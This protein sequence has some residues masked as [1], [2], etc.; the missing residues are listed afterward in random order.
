MKIPRLVVAKK[1]FA[2]LRQHQALH[3]PCLGLEN[4]KKTKQKEIRNDFNCTFENIL[5]TTVSYL[6][7]KVSCWLAD[8]KTI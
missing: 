1:T 7:F 3:L 6:Q 5:V 2:E 8:L 4:Q